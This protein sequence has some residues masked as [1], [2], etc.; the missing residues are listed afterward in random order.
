[1]IDSNVP[2]SSTSW[3]AEQQSVAKVEA[4]YNPPMFTTFVSKT[5]AAAILKSDFNQAAIFVVGPENYAATLIIGAAEQAFTWKDKLD[6]IQKGLGLNISQLAA[7][8]GV[9]RQQLYNWRSDEVDD[10]AQESQASIG[11]LYAIYKSLEDEPYLRFLGKLAKRKVFS[12]G[13]NFLEAIN[14]NLPTEEIK[15]GIATLRPDLARFAAKAAN[16]P[17]SELSKN[18][19]DDLSAYS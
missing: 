15:T 1:M 6:C 13:R 11:R 4:P 12:D 18:A 9:S 3:L 10:P 17:T 5:Y 19:L 2:V 16:K 8:L 7:C 14:G